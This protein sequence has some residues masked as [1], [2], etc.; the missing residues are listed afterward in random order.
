MADVFTILIVVISNRDSFGADS[1]DAVACIVAVVTIFGNHAA[2][3]QS[4]KRVAA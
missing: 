2:V 3:L 1:T 4:I